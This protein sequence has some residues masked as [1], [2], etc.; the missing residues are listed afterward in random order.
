[1]PLTQTQEDQLIHLAKHGS[2]TESKD[3]I[4]T[5]LVEHQPALY[6]YAMSAL[7]D[8][9]KAEQAVQNTLIYVWQALVAGEYI[10]NPKSENPFRHWLLAACKNRNVQ[11]QHGRIGNDRQWYRERVRQRGYDKYTWTSTGQI[12]TIEQVESKVS[13]EQDMEALRLARI[14]LLPKRLREVYRLYTEGHPPKDIAVRVG[15]KPRIVHDYI[16]LSKCYLKKK[17]A[18]EV[19]GEPSQADVGKLP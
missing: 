4:N 8:H 11:V 2:S 5:L 6:Q 16:Y 9:S 10:P 12:P 15:L 1:M 19:N 17:R 7:G 18:L 14:E 3:A 13:A